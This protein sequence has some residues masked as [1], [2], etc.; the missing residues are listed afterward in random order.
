[1]QQ[2]Q[3]DHEMVSNISGK[4]ISRRLKRKNMIS[5]LCRLPNPA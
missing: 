2:D 4:T 1:M 3:N 5:I